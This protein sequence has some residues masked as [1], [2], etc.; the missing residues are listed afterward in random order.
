MGFMKHIYLEAQDA[1]DR[2]SRDTFG[3]EPSPLQ[4]EHREMFIT[5]YVQA[6]LDQATKRNQTKE[7]TND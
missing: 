2:Y 1:F 6:L 3:F 4:I 5:G 7:N